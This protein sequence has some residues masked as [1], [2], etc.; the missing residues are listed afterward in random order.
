MFSYCYF[1]KADSL[2]ALTNYT[3]ESRVIVAEHVGLSNGHDDMEHEQKEDK[4]MYFSLLKGPNRY[5]WHSE[6]STGTQRHFP[7]TVMRSLSLC[8]QQGAI[9]NLLIPFCACNSVA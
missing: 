2:C 7:L 3:N 6:T 4:K 1:S 5:E 9:N 8:P